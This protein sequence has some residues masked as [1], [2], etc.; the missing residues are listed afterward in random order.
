MTTAAA[1]PPALD[2][3]DPVLHVRGEVTHEHR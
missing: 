1:R 2:P 3:L